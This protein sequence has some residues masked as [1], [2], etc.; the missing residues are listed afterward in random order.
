[1]LAIKSKVEGFGVP[2][3]IVQTQHSVKCCSELSRGFSTD[4]E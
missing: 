1:M 4:K 3:N 2:W